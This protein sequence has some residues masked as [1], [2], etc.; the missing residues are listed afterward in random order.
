MLLKLRFSADSYNPKKTYFSTQ[1]K[2]I[3][4][5]SKEEVEDFY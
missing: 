5:G 1:K 2:L 4:V 3:R